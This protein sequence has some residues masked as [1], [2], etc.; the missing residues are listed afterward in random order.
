MRA[1]Q[2]KGKQLLWGTLAAIAL[3]VINSALHRFIDGTLCIIT[4]IVILL[5]WKIK[6]MK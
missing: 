2:Q 6:R 4:G 3:G 5:I 1:N